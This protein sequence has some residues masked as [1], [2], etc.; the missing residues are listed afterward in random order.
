M[1]A[2][3]KSSM[4]SF[5]S[6]HDPL[7]NSS[8]FTDDYLTYRDQEGQQGHRTSRC[9]LS[10]LATM[11]FAFMIVTGQVTQYVT[12]PLWIDSTTSSLTSAQNETVKWKPTVDSYFVLS[13]AC[14]SFVAVFGSVLLCTDF[15]CPKYSAVRTDWSYRRLLLSVG[16]FQGVS[17]I[18]IVFS[19]S[20]NR[21]PPYLQAILG[22]FS[23]PITLLLR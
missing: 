8:A 16:L 6:D 7:I 12:L 3:T 18:F 14:L 1:S 19:S 21:T 10:S 11:L 17:G 2:N 15:I 20:G 22:N 23:I 5:P 9:S 13:F 4:N